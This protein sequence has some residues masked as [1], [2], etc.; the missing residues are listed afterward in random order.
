MKEVAAFQLPERFKIPD[1]PVYTGQ[2]DPME[3]LD[4]FLAH[5]DLNGTPNEVAC[6][7]FPLTMA[8]SARDW[9]RKLPPRSI[10]NFDDLGRIFLTQFMAGVMRK[11]PAGS[12][13]CIRQ[14]PKEL[15][16]DYLTRFNQEKL[17]TE[18]CTE[19]FVYCPLF[20][21]IRKDEPLIANLARKSPQNLQEFMDGVDEFINQEETLQALLGANISRASS[22]REK[23]E[24]NG[25]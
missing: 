9:F 24:Q 5:L 20:K 8:G 2:V 21:G 18:S 3:H 16:K 11:K 14:G 13:I 12:L 25:A 4:N 6:R 22:S 19:E 15:L 23:K 7:A 1:I 17:A 10:S